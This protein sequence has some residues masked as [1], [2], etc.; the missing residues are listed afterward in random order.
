MVSLL[1]LS[2]TQRAHDQELTLY[3]VWR[4]RH[5]ET[6]RIHELLVWW[7]PPRLHRIFFSDGADDRREISGRVCPHPAL[8]WSVR[9]G[10]LH[11]RALAEASRPSAITPLMIA[12]YWNTD[13]PR[14]S[15]CEGDMQ[16]PR[17]TDVTTM[18]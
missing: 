15:V 1:R 17:E 11:L 2:R 6:F 13:P 7:T 8:L 16:R 9:Q 12:P 5:R 14:G 18:L 10:S 3:R 4:S